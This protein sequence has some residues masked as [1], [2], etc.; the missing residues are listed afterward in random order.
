M[1]LESRR[2]GIEKSDL[3]SFEEIKWDNSS[4]YQTSKNRLEELQSLKDFL[5]T[6][7]KEEPIFSEQEAGKATIYSTI[8][9]KEDMEDETERYEAELEGRSSEMLSRIEDLFGR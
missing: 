7:D 2:K 5:D 8:Q 4:S 3:D 1:G 9:D 6:F